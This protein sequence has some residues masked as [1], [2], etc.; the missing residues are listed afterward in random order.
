MVGLLTPSRER[1]A[2][3]RRNILDGYGRNRAY[4][5]GSARPRSRATHDDA[6]SL[7]AAAVGV[8]AALASP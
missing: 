7:A 4:V 6:W 1:L 8:V 5:E 3:Q 2:G